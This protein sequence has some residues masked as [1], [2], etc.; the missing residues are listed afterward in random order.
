MIR[1]IDYSKPLHITSQA[2]LSEL[3]VNVVSL[4]YAPLIKEKA[5]RIYLTLYSMLNRS[6]LE[7]TIKAEE[8]MTLLNYNEEDCKQAEGKLEALG[9]VNLYESDT[10]YLLLLKNPLTPKQ[11][12]TDGVLGMYLYSIIGDMAFN[13]F[14]KL[15]EIPKFD[16]NEYKN[17]TSS[18]DEFYVTKDLPKN[19]NY[20]VNKKINNGIVINNKNFDFEVFKSLISENFLDGRRIS[21]KFKKFINDIAFAYQLDENDMQ[22]IYNRSLNSSGYFDYSL[23]SKN[24]RS[25]YKERHNDAL[26]QMEEKNLNQDV[27]RFEKML[28]NYHP[29]NLLESILGSKPKEEDVVNIANLYAA[30]PE[31]SKAIINACVLYSIKLCNDKIPAYGYYDKVMKDWTSKGVNS[32]EKAYQILTSDKKKGSYIQKKAAEEPDWL[33]EHWKHFEEGVEDL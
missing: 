5:L 13:R 19:N 6:N 14:V 8:L 24:A 28:D 16:K 18:F 4:L 26:P 32:F 3:D 10:E 23:C 12:L 22:T 2:Y 9:L 31:Y 30:Y 29:N 1:E 17:I 15:F 33:K 25:L 21:Q 27:Y 11:F 7:T 20:F